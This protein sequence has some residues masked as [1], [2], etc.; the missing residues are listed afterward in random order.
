MNAKEKSVQE[1]PTKV[2]NP[3]QVEA[4][5]G[6]VLPYDANEREGILESVIL[7]ERQVHRLMRGG[8]VA[9]ELEA[10]VMFQDFRTRE[11]SFIEEKTRIL[12][13]RNAGNHTAAVLVRIKPGRTKDFL[14]FHQVGWIKYSSPESEAAFIRRMDKR[15]AE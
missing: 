12:I 2:F 13:G 6:H 10:P 15:M 1:V 3:W 14:N 11:K 9:V 8:N 4:F 7:S 5:Y